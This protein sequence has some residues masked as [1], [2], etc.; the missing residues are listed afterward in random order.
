MNGDGT[1]FRYDFQQDGQI[2]LHSVVNSSGLQD[3][4]PTS[5]RSESS[6]VTS[7][8]QYSNLP[9]PHIL[10][11]GGI[12]T[13][14]A[15]DRGLKPRR[16]T[17]DSA[18]S[19]EPSPSPLSQHSVGPPSVDRKLKPRIYPEDLSKGILKFHVLYLHCSIIYFFILNSTCPFSGH[20]TLCPPPSKRQDGSRT[21]RPT[22]T[23]P[24]PTPPQP[25]GSAPSTLRNGFR[26]RTDHPSSSDDDHRHSPDDDPVDNIFISIMYFSL[27]IFERKSNCFVFSPFFISFTN[28]TAFYQWAKKLNIWT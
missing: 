6:S 3:D 5:P 17:S 27:Q 19:N 15:V 8:T 10:P 22:R 23:G 4:E 9:S 25:P 26:S 16:K 7:A 12:P 1:V 18:A 24:S 14:P 20:L 28:R 21:L 11:P 13:P 2:P